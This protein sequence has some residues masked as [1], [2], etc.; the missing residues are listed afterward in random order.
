MKQLLCSPID[1]L[2]QYVAA[3]SI[4]TMKDYHTQRKL[5]TLV[6]IVHLSLTSMALNNSY[7]NSNPVRAGD[8]AG[9][10]IQDQYTRS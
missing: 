4:D 2:M 5:V 1:R 7:E 3:S 6:P 8:R 10:S 9:L